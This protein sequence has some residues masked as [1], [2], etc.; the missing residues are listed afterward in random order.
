[1]Q[2]I[3][4]SCPDG[5]GLF[6]SL[7]GFGVSVEFEHSQWLGHSS[8]DWCDIL[9][10]G[11]LTLYELMKWM[12]LSWLR[13]K[14]RNPRHSGEH[15]FK[16]GNSHLSQVGLYRRNKTSVAE[17]VKMYLFTFAHDRCP[18]FVSRGAV[19]SVVTKSPQDDDR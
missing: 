5:L 14:K 15:E 11:L 6:S 10:L 16:V 7:A 12:S 17:T 13:I 4:M 3:S 19:L 18:A 2:L 1:M 8:S 9:Q